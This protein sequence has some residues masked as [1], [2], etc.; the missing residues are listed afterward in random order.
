[1]RLGKCQKNGVAE[2]VVREGKGAPVWFNVAIV[3]PKYL[4]IRLNEPQDIQA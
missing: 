1:L 3:A 2:A 4:E